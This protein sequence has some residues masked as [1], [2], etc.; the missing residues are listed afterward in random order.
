MNREFQENMAN[1][2]I[3]RRQRDLKNAGLNP[4]L[5]MTQ[6]EASTPTGATGGGGQGAGIISTA[7]NNT[8]KKISKEM[9]KEQLE[10]MKL[11]NTA[12]KLNI[13]KIEQELATA[14]KFIK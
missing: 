5:A 13:K 11:Q 7:I 6:G 12:A 8:A 2:E 9:G 14:A 3:Q 10:S 1:T 4:I